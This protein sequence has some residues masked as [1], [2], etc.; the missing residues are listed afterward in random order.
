MGIMVPLFNQRTRYSSDGYSGSIGLQ[1]V[2]NKVILCR[3]WVTGKEFYH[4]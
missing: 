4:L 3:P 2:T 1:I